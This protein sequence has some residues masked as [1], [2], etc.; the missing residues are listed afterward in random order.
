MQRSVF[1]NMVTVDRLRET[2]DGSKPLPEF[3]PEPLF[4]KIE[5]LFHEFFEAYKEEKGDAFDPFDFDHEYPDYHLF[6]KAA[7]YA[8]SADPNVTNVVVEDGLYDLENTHDTRIEGFTASEIRNMWRI[9]DQ[10]FACTFV[11][12]GTRDTENYS[13][14]DRAAL[15]AKILDGFLGGNLP[16]TDSPAKKRVRLRK[17]AEEEEAQP[18][19]RGSDTKRRKLKFSAIHRRAR[20]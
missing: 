16:S 9:A 13:N 1:P 7:L 8:S 11:F 5:E 14:D 4:N 3:F 20:S 12:V 19:A 10:G 2:H 15:S 17:R 18:P 6:C